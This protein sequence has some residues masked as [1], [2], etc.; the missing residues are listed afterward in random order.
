Y[1]YAAQA[2]GAPSLDNTSVPLVET[3]ISN[4]RCHIFRVAARCGCAFS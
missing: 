2:S 4:R 1:L 3:I